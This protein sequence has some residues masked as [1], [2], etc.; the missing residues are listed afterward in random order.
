MN[1]NRIKISSNRSFG[2]V[3]FIFFLLIGLYPIL[4]NES[5]RIIP[6]CLALIFLFLGLI[7]SKLLYPLNWLWFKFGV[8]LGIFVSPLILALI[9]FFV[10]F[11]TG[12]FIKLIKN[13]FLGLKFDKDL[14]T[15]WINKEKIK[16]SMKDQF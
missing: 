8:I 2:I 13:N 15:Y 14:K 6:T 16:S 9:F 10:V 5:I 11:P 1:N 7:N 12:V 4:N 3:F